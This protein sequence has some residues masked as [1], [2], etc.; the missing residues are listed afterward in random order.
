MLILAL[1]TSTPAVSVALC[2]D[3]EALAVRCVVDARRHGELLA[4]GVAAVLEEAQVKPRQLEAIAAGVGPGPYTGLRVGLMTAHSLAHALG[5]AVHGV[6]SLDVLA[7][8]AARQIDAEF[9]VATDAR[10]KEVYWARYGADGVRRGGPAVDTPAAVAWEGP[11]VGQGPVLYPHSFP[12]ARAPLHPDPVVLAAI[13]EATLS[14]GE[15][16]T[17]PQPLYLR[18]PDAVEPGAR[19]RAGA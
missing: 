4:V 17:A 19:K 8:A 5:I 13:V 11:T 2:R 1:D 18:R 10:R 7:R 9:L 14:A 12:D 15:A 3:G 6:C 16:T